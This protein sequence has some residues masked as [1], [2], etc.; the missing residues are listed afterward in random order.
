M[1]G[2]RRGGMTRGSR[3]RKSPNGDQGQS[4]VGVPPEAEE[5]F[6]VENVGFNE[7]RSRAWTVGLY[8]ENN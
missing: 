7:Y 6:P 4:P 2:S 5:R 8:F 1:G 3:G